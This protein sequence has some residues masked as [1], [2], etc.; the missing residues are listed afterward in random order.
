MAFIE[1]IFSR[2]K[3]RRNEEYSN[4]SQSM[5]DWLDFMTSLLNKE[6]LIERPSYADNLKDIYSTASNASKLNK[7]VII[8]ADDTITE[9]RSVYQ[10]FQRAAN[11][12]ESDIEFHNTEYLRGKIK[13]AREIIGKIEGHD[14]DDQQMMCILKDA[15]NHNVVAGAGTGKTTTIIGKVKYLLG[16][17]KFK[18][19]E[20]LVLSYTHAAA[21][22]MAKRLKENT[23]CDIGV[24]TFH[25]FGYYIMT[26]VEKK[27]PV[28]FNKSMR[29]VLKN[30]LQDLVKDRRYSKKLLRFL[31]NSAGTGKSDIDVE[32]ESA[33]E[34]RQYVSE[35]KPLTL[36]SEIVKSYG[37]M[38]VAN[39]LA[40]NGI[41]YEYE[42]YYEHDTATEEHA[43]YAPD[44]YLP[45]YGI[46]IE[47]FGIDRNGKAPEW[48]EGEDPT[49]TYQQGMAWKRATHEQYE[50]KL[51]EC[52]AYED[53]EGIL[54]ESLEKKLLTEGVVLKEV[55]FDDVM[56]GTGHSSDN[57]VNSFL[58]NAESVI[59][60]A[61]NRKLSADGLLK[62]ASGN[63]EA[64]LA[65]EVIAPLQ[66]SY[67]EYLRSSQQ[68]DFSDMLITAEK[69]IK[70]GKYSNPFKC[71]IIDEYQDITA[72]QF[73]LLK[74]MR[75]RN[76][77][78]LFCVG[79][80]WQSIYRFNGSDVSYIMDFDDFW[81]GSELSRIETTYRF[82]QSLIDVSSFFIM[83]NPRQ[84][85]KSIRSG[86]KDR[87]YAVSK[88]EGYKAKNAIQFMADRM[89]YLPK[90]STVFLIGRYTFDIDLLKEESRLSVRYSTALQVQKVYLQG[91]SDLDITFYTAH[92]SKGLQADY[93]FILNNTNSTLGFPSKVE[94]SVLTDM[95]LEHSDSFPFAEERRLFYVALTRARKHVYLVTV[96]GWES[97]FE[98]EI[99][100]QCGDKL[101]N[102]TYICPVCGGKLILREG[103]FGKFFGCENYNSEKKCR[104]TS[105]IS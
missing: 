26:S 43:Q 71:V 67:E 29:D 59:N 34:Y 2:Y 55:S 76:D 75:D 56:R 19:E 63:N 23:S 46:Y 60:L 10:K 57:M 88:I 8:L 35:H 99:E 85:K 11:S 64:M 44:F 12:F 65:A 72:S 49:R 39:C 78:D 74:A 25:R 27:K 86:S 30:K 84:I 96:K 21:A 90:D 95:L 80:D 104:F 3:E 36:K 22:E 17:G 4:L 24:M 31:G 62:R 37:E 61:R 48:F 5:T 98:E 103:R 41:K 73:R 14:L 93:V 50:T 81:G 7:R 94:D 92:R 87:S 9:Y 89:M 16:T 53:Q 28:I 105:T 38:R 100:E 101:K 102:E 1:K 45:D 42:R 68:I 52:Y 66:R 18:P 83:Q 69:Y 79:D 40:T 15:H 54:E 82:S 97:V 20:I 58:S 70:E 33:E 13:E 91:R 32:F 6:G 47:F 77:F 51:I